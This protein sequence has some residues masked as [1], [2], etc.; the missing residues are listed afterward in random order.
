[1]K[2]EKHF[3]KVV[4]ITAAIGVMLVLASV[5]LA[6]GWYVVT[7]GGEAVAG[8]FSSLSDCTDMAKIMHR[9][10]SNVSEICQ[11]K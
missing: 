8:P 5:A 4:V 2:L 11:V 6:G 7:Y 9:K 1:M 10:Y 3:T